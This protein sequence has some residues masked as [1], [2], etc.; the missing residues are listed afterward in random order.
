MATE[1]RDIINRW[2]NKHRK[3]AMLFRNQ[4]GGAWGGKI[5]NKTRSSITLSPYHWLDFGLMKGSGDYIGWRTITVTP[6]MVGKPIAVFTSV[7][8]KTPQ[9][10][11]TD[12][13][14]LW[15]HRVRAA[16]G[17]ALV[18][19]DPDQIPCDWEG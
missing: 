4:V 8:A 12:D 13:Q 14:K 5:I 19:R 9:G 16:G 15:T 7:E 2:L 11:L 1:E 3:W 6:D 18:V 17:I 10:H